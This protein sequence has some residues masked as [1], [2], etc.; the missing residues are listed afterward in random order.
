MPVYPSGGTIAQSVGSPG[1]GPAPAPSYNASA[2]VRFNPADTA[3][4]S[5]IPTLQGSR[6]TWTWSGWVKRSGLSTLQNLFAARSGNESTIFRL[7]TNDTLLF[8]SQNSSSTATSNYTTA[9]VFRDVSAWYHVLVAIDT[10]QTTAVNRVSIYINGVL[11]TLTA[12]T[13]VAQYAQLS[14]NGSGYSHAI[15]FQPTI[16]EYFSGYLADINFVDGLALTPSSFTATDANT[17]QLV[18][19]QYAGNRGTNGFYLPFSSA[20]LA[21][22]LGQNPKTTAQD[23]PY[24]PYNTLLVDTTNTNGQNNNTFLDSSTNN[25]TI[26]RNGNTTQG[27]FTPFN[28][29]GGTTQANGYYSGYFDGT[30]DYLSLPASGNASYINGTGNFTIDFWVYYNALPTGSVGANTGCS[31]YAQDSG[32]T[33][34]SPFNLIQAGNTWYLYAD[35]GAGTWNIFSQVTIATTTLSSGQWYHVACVRDSTNIRLYINGVQVGTASIG[36]ASIWQNTVRNLY[37][38]GAWQNTA[39]ST[40]LNGYVSNYRL[41][42]GTCLYPNGTTFTVPTTPLT[43]ITNTSLLTCQSSQFIDNS[44][45]AFAITANGNAQPLPTNPF[46]MTAWSGY[47]DGTGDYLSVGD[48]SAF[49]FGSGNYTVE[50]WWFATTSADQNLIGKWDGGGSEWILQWRNA[51]Y[52][53]WAANG[54]VISDATISLSLNTWNHIA[55]SKSGTSLRIFVNGIQ[56]NTTATEGTI[57]ATSASLTI[58]AA[59][60]NSTPLYTTGQLSNIRIVKGTAVYTS[61]FTVPTAPL[62]AIS[63][64]SLLTCQSSTFIDNSTNAFPITVNGNSYTGTLNNPFGNPINYTTPPVQA[65]S[66]YFDGAGDYLS[67]TVSAA[68]VGTGDFTIEFFCYLPQALDANDTLLSHGYAAAAF[69]NGWYLQ[70]TGTRLSFGLGSASVGNSVASNVDTPVRRWFHFAIT[71]VGSLLRVWQDGLL[72][73][74]MTNA[75]NGTAT[76]FFTIASASTNFY[77]TCNISNLRI[78]KG[79]S[80]Y[81]ANFTV[82]TSPL[83][84]VQNTSLLTCQSNTFVDNSITNATVTKNGDAL[85]S[86]LS[87][88]I[89]TQSWS[90]ASYGGTM[91]FDGTGDYLS[92]AD[93]ATLEFGSSNFTIEAFIY[94]TATTGANRPIWS[95]GT[96]STNWMSLYLHTTAGRPEFAI[97]SGGSTIVDIWPA[98]VI[99]PNIWY[100]LAVTRSGSTFRMFLNGALIGTGTNASAVPDYTDDYRV[101]FGR[102]SGDT[103]VYAGNISGLRI[104]KGTALYTTPFVPPVLPPTAVTNTTL[105]LNATNAGIYDATGQ[106][107]IETVGNAQVSTAVKKWGESS[108]AFDGTGDYLVIPPNIQNYLS[109]AQTTVSNKD[110]TIEFWFYSVNTSINAVLLIRRASANP[111]GIAISQLANASLFFGAGDSGTGAWEVTYT[112]GTNAFTINSWNHIALTRQGATY[113]FFLNGVQLYTAAPAAF[114]IAG[115]TLPIYIASNAAEASPAAFNGYIQDLRLTVGAA[116]YQGNFTPPAAAFAYNQYDIG[117]QQWTPNNIS[118]TAGVGQDNLVDS[119][120]DYGTDTGLGGQVR[121]NY[122]TLNFLNKNSGITLTNGNLDVTSSLSSSERAFSTISMKSG[123]WYC[124]FSPT[125]TVIYNHVGIYADSIP[126]TSDTNRIVWRQDGPVFRDGL[127]IATITSFTNGDVIGMAFNADTLGLTYY[128]NGVLAGGPYTA[129]NPGAGN[130]FY[131]HYLAGGIAGVKSGVFNFGQRAFAY[132]APAGFKCLVSTN[133]PTVNGIGATST[134]RASNYFNANLWT[135]NGTQIPVGFDPS[136]LWYKATNSVSGAGWV[137]QIRGDNYYMQTYNTLASTLLSGL[138]TTNSTGFVPG[139]AFASN[140]YVGYSWRG[141]D[142]L[143]WSFDGSLERTATMTIAS[144]CVVT[145]ASNGFSPGQAVRFTTT[146]AL[147]TGIVANTTYYAGNMVGST[148]NLYDTEAN[149]ITGGATGRVDTSGSQSG[150]Q[151]CEHAA[152]ISANPTSGFSVTQYIG[153]GANTT[154]PHGLGAAPELW[155]IKCSGTTGDWYA[156][157]TTL[158]GSVDYT[159]LNGT[160]NLANV[161]A[162]YATLPTSTVVSVG[163]DATANTNGV[164]YMLYSYVSIP[165]FSKVGVYTGNGAADGP[166]IYTNFSP[167]MMLLKRVSGSPLDNWYNLDVPRS[168]Y[169]VVS[170]YLVPNSDQAQGSATFVDFLSNG[171]KVR[172][173]GAYENAAGSSYLYFAVAS[174]PFK[175]SRAY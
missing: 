22:D 59:Q 143:S 1:F 92:I 121:G 8:Y 69:T 28:Y 16:G 103:G 125:S 68:Q 38:F 129:T 79:Q 46:G 60:L 13:T 161:G 144:P 115:D 164:T 67:T 41:V 43:A 54:G 56:T 49:E 93:N 163:V 101:G 141:A 156:L 171:F 109:G 105:L 26:T 32:L 119:P 113:R 137:D 27:N 160:Q 72:T 61:N 19:A 114:V 97:I 24:W 162:G 30:G 122:A 78:I 40:G 76:N 146:G 12:A 18:P 104:L 14:V 128:K 89:P 138:L 134:T 52:F 36:A 127:Q 172:A 48:Q 168:P 158:D 108:I 173:A 23:F 37:L 70:S 9:A 170:N 140:T 147:P 39:G 139:S 88:F 102:W 58:A 136:L 55:I 145:L 112:S 7:A 74:S 91:Y 152:R 133:L 2:S 135:G 118:V 33:I 11:Q 31:W 175:Y 73:G 42:K 90:A 50:C 95:H 84:A 85:I 25:F 64:T 34:V 100:H 169:N 124:E 142:T 148:F 82:P 62:T 53:R 107:V 71:R 130:G 51:G 110:F 154:V 123:Q 167:E 96:N 21:V 63:G 132:T 155:F 86:S 81:N 10:T 65:W 15:G 111:I 131:Y 99:S 29:G 126:T 44:T 77:C 3:Y 149:A 116:R 17:G 4:F 47:F 66:N 150:T 57:S 117:N 151:T 80:I 87:P 157:T 159:F 153:I 6:T 106:N 5:Y 98:D 174:A 94:P 166:M 45:N 165:G 20:T 83:T 75:Q 35:T 120:S